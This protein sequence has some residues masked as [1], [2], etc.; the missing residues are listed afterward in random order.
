[1]NIWLNLFEKP[2][3][4]S[5][6]GLHAQPDKRG[7]A[8]GPLIRFLEVCLSFIDGFPDHTADGLRD[9]VTRLKRELTAKSGD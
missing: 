7:R 1:M 9:H 2:I 6:F 4:T 5:T 3:S 8:T